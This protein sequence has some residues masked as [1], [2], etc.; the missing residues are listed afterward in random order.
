MSSRTQHTVEIELLEPS[1][2]T[3]DRHVNT[4]PVDNAWV[5]RKIRE[6]FDMGRLGV[7]QVSARPDG[8]YIWLDGQNRGALCI[9]ADHGD[10]KIGMK[11]FRGLTRKQE[12]ELFLGLNDNR[13]VQPLYK[14][15][16]EVTA[17]H[18]EAL[19]ITRAA[20]DHGWVISDSGSSNS[21][22]AVAALRKIYG[23]SSE[24]GQL[25]RRT[26]RIV[27]DAWGNTSSAANSY[28]LLGVA[29]VLFEFP[30]LDSD[31]LVRKLSKSPGGPA[32]LLGKGRGYK[33]V[34][35]GTVVEGIARVVRDTYNSGRRSGKLDMDSSKPF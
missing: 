16:A 17:G 32:S 4:R 18:P 12:A 6:G 26:L 35:G 33:A 14:F 15:M 10:T 31:A 2:V 8:T 27:T 20:H 29:S 21:I 30:F 25:L 1:Q 24:K 34:T 5:A 11:V 19:A 9:A 28:V 13:R 7:P 3:T 23:K 22:I